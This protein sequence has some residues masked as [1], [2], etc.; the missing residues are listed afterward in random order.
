MV[1]KE[2]YENYRAIINQCLET[3]LKS[4][5]W[6]NAMTYFYKLNHRG[7]IPYCPCRSNGFMC[8]SYKEYLAH[9]KDVTR[10]PRRP[11]NQSSLELAMKEAGIEENKIKKTF[12]ILEEFRWKK[13][14]V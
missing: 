3:E 13:G 4:E 2:T 7:Q 9:N 11:L 10:K 1:K 8:P 14:T 12:E 6:R 5:E